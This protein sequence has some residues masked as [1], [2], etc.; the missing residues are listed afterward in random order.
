MVL[1]RSVLGIEV[2]EFWFDPDAFAKSNATVSLLRT[3][4]RVGAFDAVIPEKTIHI[5]L[6]KDIGALFADISPRTKAYIRKAER[7][8]RISVIDSEEKRDRFYGAYSS[9]AKKHGLLIPSREE[10]RDMEIM[11]AE[12]GAGTLL[13]AAGF[14]PFGR[15]GIY[16]Y[17]YSVSVEKS[18]AFKLLLWHAVCRAREMGFSIFDMGGIPRS[19][20]SSKKYASILFFKSQFG[21]TPVD[22]YLYIRTKNPAIKTA[23]RLSRPLLQTEWIFSRLMHVASALARI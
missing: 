2:R 1:A 8:L 3:N 11:I 6:K 17:R 22:T 23:L 12:D 5:D 14:L 15:A 9:F 21:G 10:E 13:H 19:P 4:E 20:T 16:R 18:Q 7:E